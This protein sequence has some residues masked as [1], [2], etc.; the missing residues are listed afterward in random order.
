MLCVAQVTDRSITQ[1]RGSRTNSVLFEQLS[2]VQ[3]YGI[4]L[5]CLGGSLP[6]LALTE[7]GELDFFAGCVLDVRAQATAGGSV[8][9]IHR[10]HV[11]SE[12]VVEHVIGRAIIG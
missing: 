6:D 9:D 11:Q 10:R 5:C 2:D 7:V 1:R 12:R 3:P 8:T 4:R